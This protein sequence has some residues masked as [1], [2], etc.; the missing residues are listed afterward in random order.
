MPL[1]KMP[2]GGFAFLCRGRQRPRRCRYCGGT[3]NRLCD[4]P[5]ERNGQGGTCDRPICSRCTTRISG[6]RD[7]CRAHAPL[8]DMQA[9]R[10]RVG[11]GAEERK[12]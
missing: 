7:L 1:V 9:D 6:E 5:V 2:N 12:P 10:P 8:W 3:S 4:F 11:P